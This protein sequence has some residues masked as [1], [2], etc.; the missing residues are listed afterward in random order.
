MTKIVQTYSKY[1]WDSS[2]PSIKNKFSNKET[3]TL[4]EPE[5]AFWN[6][7]EENA[8]CVQYNQ[9]RR[10]VAHLQQWSSFY[11]NNFKNS[12]CSVRTQF[13]VLQ[14]WGLGRLAIQVYVLHSLTILKIFSVSPIRLLNAGMIC[15]GIR[16]VAVLHLL[17]SFVAFMYTTCDVLFLVY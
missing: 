12:T 8:W 11:T 7:R 6:W 16:T 14:V 13:S 17:T 3:V 5:N 4:P 10:V 1:F 15:R 9:T 2:L